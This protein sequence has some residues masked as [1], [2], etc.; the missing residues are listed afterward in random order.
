MERRSVKYC[1][2]QLFEEMVGSFG[3]AI[4][5]DRLSSFDTDQTASTCTTFYPCMCCF[6]LSAPAPWKNSPM[7]SFYDWN[8]DLYA[9]NIYCMSN[10]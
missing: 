5:N 2:I 7:D 4:L 9:Y 10:D 8:N 3:E 6:H 1:T